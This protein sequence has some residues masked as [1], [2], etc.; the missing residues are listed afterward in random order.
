MKVTFIGGG[1]M[2]EAILSAVLDKGLSTPRSIWISD[3][4][5]TRLQ[6]LRE[7]YGVTVISNNLLAAE[8]G[9][10]VILA[11]KPQA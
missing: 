9:E 2:G 1:N 3:V 8:K 5:E 11:I 7:Q 4:Q 6:Y 10:V